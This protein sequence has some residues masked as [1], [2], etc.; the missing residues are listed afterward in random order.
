M[1]DSMEQ[2]YILSILF[3]VVLLLH[4]FLPQATIFPRLSPTCFYTSCSSPFELSPLVLVLHT[5]PDCPQCFSTLLVLLHLCC[6]HWSW[7]FTVAN[8]FLHF[9]FFSVCVVSAGLGISHLPQDWELCLAIPVSNRWNVYFGV[10]VVA[11]SGRW[12]S[13]VSISL[14]LLPSLHWVSFLLHRF[15]H[16]ALHL[17]E[18]VSPRMAALRRRNSYVSHI[19]ATIVVPYGRNAI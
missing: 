2:S 8:V 4:V 19:F 18:F 13:R 11:T 3:R 1:Y 12:F 9:L 10:L 6:L 17:S 15:F 5:D 16:L 14:S 7:Y